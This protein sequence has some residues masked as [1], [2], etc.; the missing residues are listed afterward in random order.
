MI[1][2]FEEN[3]VHAETFEHETKIWFFRIKYYVHV[4]FRLLY[5]DIIHVNAIPIVFTTLTNLT[6]LHYY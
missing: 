1:V 3:T 5:T 6:D 4:N 2:L